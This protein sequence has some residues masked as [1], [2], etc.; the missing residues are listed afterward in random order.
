VGG[1]VD[2]QEN[3]NSFKFIQGLVIYR[4][5]VMTRPGSKR[6]NKRE[7]AA[8]R[9]S[10]PVDKFEKCAGFVLAALQVD[11]STIITK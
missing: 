11:S 10:E 2:D 3:Q 1:G 7:S 6:R 9:L 5:I 4:S 8:S